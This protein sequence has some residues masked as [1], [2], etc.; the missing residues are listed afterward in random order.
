MF[1]AL[2]I[3]AALKQFFMDYGEKQAVV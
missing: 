1:F 3:H 2:E